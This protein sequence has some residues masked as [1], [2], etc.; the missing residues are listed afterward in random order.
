MI[1]SLPIDVRLQSL[2]RI[3]DKAADLSKGRAI[4][5]PSIPLDP[6]LS[7]LRQGDVEHRRHFLFGVHPQ[8]ISLTKLG[9]EHSSVGSLSLDRI[10]EILVNGSGSGGCFVHFGGLPLERIRFH[11]DLLKYTDNLSRWV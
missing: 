11:G 7:K 6:P 2:L 4:D 10:D 8:M 9:Q 1:R 5:P 3:S